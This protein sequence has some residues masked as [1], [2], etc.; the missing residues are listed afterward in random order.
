MKN[1]WEF[2][3]LGDVCET[4]AG[5]T[6]L[7][8]HKEYY[9]G[10]TIPWL[11]SGEV[12]QGEIFEAKNFITEKGYKNSSARLFPSNTILIAMYGATAGQV[13]ILRFK[14][15]TN[16]AVCGI[17]PN[18]K[19]IPE[20][21]YYF[22]Q[23]KKKE[24][25]DQ[26]VGGAQPN[27]SQIK[28]KNTLVPCV[29][30]PEQQ[31]IVAILDQAFAAIDAAKANAAKNLQNA[32]ELFETCLDNIFTGKRKDWEYKQLGDVTYLITDGKH[33]DCVNENS[34]GFY[35]LSAK[36]VKN[37]TLNYENARQITKVDFEETHRRTNLQP[38]DVLITNAGTIGRVA[39]APLDDKTYRTTFQ[40]SVAVI[41]PNLSIIKS[42]F[43]KYQLEAEA[44]NLINVSAGAAQKNLLLR[45][46]KNLMISIPPIS[47][48][49]III[50]KLDVLLEK[51]IKLEAI[52][53][54]KLANLDELKQS[55]LQKAFNGELSEG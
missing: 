54:Q 55:L 22:F 41:K 2:K 24:L 35:F 44:K 33:G 21:L 49:N 39:I 29:P 30:L 6:P 47:E 8:A 9:V 20:F 37:G 23:S 31:R 11:L 52:Y 18:D 51:R 7:K 36:D 16:Q 42:C 14:S 50:D 43:L 28:I 48:Q 26:A 40:K 45:D 38:G 12:N 34:S 19:F 13:G 4:G 32:R 3:K 25:V 46:L 1:R 10:G 53:Q 15:S 27:I 17:L 5:G